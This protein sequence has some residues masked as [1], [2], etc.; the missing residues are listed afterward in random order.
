VDVNWNRRMNRDASTSPAP[1][2]ACRMLAF[3]V[4]RIPVYTHCSMSTDAAT[5]AVGGGSFRLGEWVVEPSLNRVSA[6]GRSVQIEPRTMDVLAYLAARAGRVVPREEILDAVWQRQFVADGTLSHTVAELRRLLGDS[7]RQPRFIE[8]ISKRGYRVVAQVAPVIAE[9]ARAEPP[10]QG[11]AARPAAVPSVA[12][13]A[14]VDMS[15]GGDQEYLCDGIAEELINALAQLG[16]LRVVA[17]TSSFAFKG[18]QEDVRE[19][20]RRLGVGSVLEGSVRKAAGRLRVTAQLIDVEDGMHLW[21]ERF[22]RADEDVFAIQDAIAEAV[23][24][25]LKVRLLGDEAARLAGSGTA[26]REAYDQYLRGRHLLNRRRVGELSAAVS[27]LE[28]AIALDPAY[29]EPHAALAETFG[30]MGLWGFAPPAV[31]LVRARVAAERAV[32]LDDRSAGAHAW[33]GTLLYYTEWDW[34][35]GNRH[36]A[37]AMALPRPSWTAGF[38]LGIHH[39]AMGRAAELAATCRSLVES[40]P[41]SA[42]AHTQAG[43]FYL[44]IDELGSAQRVLDRALELDPE[45]PMAVFWK[46]WVSGALGHYGVSAELL[47]R[48]LEAGMTASALVL[49]QVLVRAGRAAEASAAVAAVERLAAERY[50]APLV[51]AF[52]WAAVEER[53]RAEALLVEAEREKSPLLTMGVIGIGFQRLGPDWLAARLAEVRRRIG[54]ESLRRADAAR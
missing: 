54:L 20:G 42:I 33:L 22:D 48:S 8:T 16:G 47:R 27:H 37:R 2:G 29:A 1:G 52:S 28:R 34:E 10:H 38:G 19:I 40:E 45:L 49:P 43:S 6:G 9:A 7:P 14:F 23:V 31:A 41:L 11:Q 51:R 50:V 32:A 5:I 36:F 21:S 24:S 4:P 35:G 25:N 3:R 39:L 44:A 13:L 12:V 18:R 53:Q 30:I 26:S 17:R 15:A 46:G